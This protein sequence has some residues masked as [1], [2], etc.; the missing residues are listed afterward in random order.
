[1]PRF[2]CRLVSAAPAAALCLSVLAARP[3]AAQ[4]LALHVKWT[5]DSTVTPSVQQ[6]S[7]GGQV[8]GSATIHLSFQIPAS[9]PYKS[10]TEVRAHENAGHINDFA[11]SN[12]TWN[13][14]W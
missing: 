12:P 10:V 4:T 2:S 9:C 11:V 7:T 8:G 14:Q 3:C 1:M 13:G 5:Q 6:R